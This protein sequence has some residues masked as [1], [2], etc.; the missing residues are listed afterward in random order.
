MQFRI[1]K[2]GWGAYYV[3]MRQK[4]GWA[5]NSNDREVQ[6]HIDISIV[7]EFSGTQDGRFLVCI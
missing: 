5:V 2:Y 7:L 6:R 1:S 3:R 4:V